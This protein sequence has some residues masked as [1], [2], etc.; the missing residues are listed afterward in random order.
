MLLDYK[1]GSFDMSILN[2]EI[3]NLILRLDLTGSSHGGR[4]EKLPN[5]V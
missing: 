3:D 1:G 5:Y 4:L 2:K